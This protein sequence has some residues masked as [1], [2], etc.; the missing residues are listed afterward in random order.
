M[1]TDPTAEREQTLA[2]SQWQSTIPMLLP[3]REALQP[4]AGCTSLPSEAA[5]S[6]ASIGHAPTWSMVA[7]GSHL[8]RDR[9]QGWGLGGLLREAGTGHH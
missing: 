7:T 4:A 9:V 6:A 3:F 2:M 5:A 1:C 8:L